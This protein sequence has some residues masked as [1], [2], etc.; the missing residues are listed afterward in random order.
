MFSWCC[1][2]RVSKYLGLLKC[3]IT[4][5]LQRKTPFHLGQGK[6]GR[7][8]RIQIEAVTQIKVVSTNN[9]FIISLFT[10]HHWDLY[11]KL[12]RVVRNS[13]F[14]ELSRRRSWTTGW[15]QQSNKYGILPCNGCINFL[16]GCKHNSLP[17]GPVQPYLLLI[18]SSMVYLT[19]KSIFLLKIAFLFGS[20]I[21]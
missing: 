4:L 11:V 7:L 17:L 20:G 1:E 14:M 16:G 12:I 19:V 10:L 5:S 21:S 18:K 15:A 6:G 13:S 3:W 9:L 2:A 8:L